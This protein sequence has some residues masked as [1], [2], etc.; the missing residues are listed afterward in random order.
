MAGPPAKCSHCGHQFTFDGMFSDDATGMALFRG[1]RVSCPRCGRL[2]AIQDGAYDLQAGVV[3]YVAAN[4]R[5][6]ESILRLRRELEEMRDV[7]DEARLRRELEERTPSL[8]AFV[9]SW[10]RSDVLALMAL[11]LTFIQYITPFFQQQNQP[12]SA[13]QLMQLMQQ[14]QHPAGHGP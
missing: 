9:R 13:E 8:A 12:V 1:S 14:M 7:Q 2:A 6:A 3:E 11:L 5:D 4:I 10:N